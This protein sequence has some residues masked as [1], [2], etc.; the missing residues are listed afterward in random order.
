MMPTKDNKVLLFERFFYPADIK[1]IAGINQLK[2][3]EGKP[4][5]L[6]YGNMPL[7]GLVEIGIIERGTNV[8]EIRPITGCNLRCRFCSVSPW[9][10]QREFV[11][12]PELMIKE[13]SKLIA[14]KT[15][16]LSIFI[17]SQGEPML[18][19][20]LTELISMLKK[21]KEIQNIAMV[22]NGTLLNESNIEELKKAGLNTLFISLHT[23][24]REKALALRTNPF[25]E[26]TIRMAEYAKSKGIQVAI[27]PVVIFGENDK[28]IE[29][30]AAIAS[31]KGIKLSPQ[32]Y[33]RYKFGEKSYKEKSFHDFYEWLKGLKKTN[34]ETFEPL[35]NIEKDVELSNP[36]KKG[37]IIKPRK[38]SEG[39]FKNEIICTLNDRLISVI[40][41]KNGS[42]KAKVIR[43]KDNII[44]A[45]AV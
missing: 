26:R 14:I 20:P 1:A 8:I 16:P 40:N 23:T 7:I 28:D 11:V 37:Q 18:Y 32:N 6:L 38:I 21:I 30:L 3:L 17:N 31:K 5:T 42:I 39:F 44:V 41:S 29:E 19:S 9:K 34:P 2:T 45:K 10:R 33:L 22:T 35:L 24:T 13:L 4:A 25:P 36:F 12:E 27:T 43:T 15:K